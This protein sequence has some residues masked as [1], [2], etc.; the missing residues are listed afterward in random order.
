MSA[1][2]EGRA[3][4]L[5]EEPNFATLATLRADGT[6]HLTVIW[7]DV[8]GGDV[9]LNSAEGRAWPANIR[10]NPA[11]SIAVTNRENQYEYVEIRGRLT[12]STTDGADEH[13]DRMAKKYLEADTYP[14]RAEGE[15]RIKFRIEPDAVRYAGG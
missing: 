7:V 4:E 14:F 1:T 9:V 12:D 15:V 13:I 11:V 8:E 3:R 5:L 2:L 6:P 10:R